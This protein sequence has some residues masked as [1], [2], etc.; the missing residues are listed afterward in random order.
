[1]TSQVVLMIDINQA[2]KWD[3]K[4]QCYSDAY[5]VVKGMITVTDPNDVS[6]DK[7][8]ALKNNASFT[9]CIL[10]IT[11]TLNDNAEDLD[12]VIPMYN[13]VEYSKNYRETAGSCGIITE[14]NQIVV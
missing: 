11:N 9:S 10:K 4:H 12:I 2:N 6:Y 3:L 14:T 1:M 13:L 5:I 8:L 7:K